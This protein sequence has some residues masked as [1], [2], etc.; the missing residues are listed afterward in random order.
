MSVDAGFN[1]PATGFGASETTEGG[2]PVQDGQTVT[3]KPAND[4]SPTYQGTADVQDDAVTVTLPATVAMVAA[5]STV[6]LATSGGSGAG[7]GTAFV[8]QGA[9]TNVRFP[10]GNT[11]V[12]DGNSLPLSKEDNTGL[13]AMV[14][15]HVASDT[16]QNVALPHNY[17]VVQ[18][19]EDSLNLE[20]YDSSGSTA[21]IGRVTANTVSV[22]LANATSRVVVDQ[23]PLEIKSV[24][25][26]PS[27]FSGLIGVSGG[28]LTGL[29]LPADAAI[30]QDGSPLT[31]PVTGTYTNTITPQVNADGVITGFTLS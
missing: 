6:A 3:V 4:V 8:N 15:A 12:T 30:V 13:L 26:V 25:G 20:Q 27:G 16:F 29:T 9:L 5:N 17:G 31:V 19:G 10:A 7:N 22:Q 21:V 23:L 28:A 18:D 2:A 1:N 14:T 24:A 11:L